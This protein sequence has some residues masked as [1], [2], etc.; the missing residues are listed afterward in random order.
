MKTI[1]NLS[2]VFLFLLAGL[3]LCKVFGYKFKYL[4][5]MFVFVLISS[6]ILFFL[7]VFLSTGKKKGQ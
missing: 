6:A 5:N 7:N 4:N 3:I 1:K 2:S